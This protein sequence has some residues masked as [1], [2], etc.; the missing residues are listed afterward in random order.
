VARLEITPG[1]SEAPLSLFSSNP[2]NFYSYSET[3]DKQQLRTEKVRITHHDSTSSPFRSFY[4]ALY[5][6]C[7][8]LMLLPASDFVTLMYALATEQK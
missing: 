2:S 6:S 1:I 8:L 5:M 7:I 4:Y 3:P